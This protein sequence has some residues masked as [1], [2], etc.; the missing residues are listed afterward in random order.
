[1]ATGTG[2]GL[3]LA[4]IRLSRLSLQICCGEEAMKVAVGFVTKEGG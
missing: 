1:M 3:L 2:V 4:A